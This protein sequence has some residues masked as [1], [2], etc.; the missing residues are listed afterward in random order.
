MSRKIPTGT[1]KVRRIDFEDEEITEEI[2]T[3]G[4]YKVRI[5]TKSS[6]ASFPD[7]MK[8]VNK[9]P[10]Y[11]E[12][13]LRYVIF[14]ELNDDLEELIDLSSSWKVFRFYID[15]EIIKKDNL[16]R[17]KEAL[18]CEYRNNCDGICTQ[19]TGSYNRMGNYE[20]INIYRLIDNINNIDLEDRWSVRNILE[21]EK[22]VKKTE[23]DEETKYFID[24]DMLKDEIQNKYSIFSKYCNLFDFDKIIEQLD[25]I[26]TQFVVK[27]DIEYISSEDSVL[28]I[29]EESDDF[30]SELN[31]QFLTLSEDQMDLLAQKIGKEMEKVLKKLMKEKK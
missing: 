16:F 15:G 12:D 24:L 7:V 11:V 10:N 13:D 20:S 27:K 17:I 14:D 1:T 23:N 26:E 30:G 6:S 31:G 19:S 28:Y 3:E 9:Y 2:K 18:F 5:V 21:R 8:I 25:K 22:C 29:D 4:K